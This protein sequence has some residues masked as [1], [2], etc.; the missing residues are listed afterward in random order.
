MLSRVRNS[1]GK[2]IN[3][4]AAFIHPCRPTVTARPPSGPGWAHELKH[5]GYR[6]QIHVRDGRVRLY[7]MNGADWSKRYPLIIREALR[8]GGS[9]ILDAEVVCMDDSGVP[10]F[11]LLH[12]RTNDNG[13]VACA[14]DLLML[15]GDDL[16]RKPYAERKAALR[17]VLRRSRDGIQYVEHTE[18]DGA[19]MFEAACKL[20]LEGIVSKRMDSLYR[21]GPARSWLKVKNP[22]APAATRATDGT[23]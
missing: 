13:A 20:G 9:A 22:K 12:S 8:I 4:P 23:F 11:G 19:E 3:A 17:K 18:G 5:D 21:S 1:R 14:F 7:T 2:P 16:R 6:L 15:N 10:D